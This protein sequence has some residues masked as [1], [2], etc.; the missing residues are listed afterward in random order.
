MEQLREMIA[1]LQE[2]RKKQ[3]QANLRVIPILYNF[4]KALERNN[5]VGEKNVTMIK[6]IILH[7]I[8]HN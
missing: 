6:S 8:Y 1:N 4:I 3:E 2:N 5:D 7:I